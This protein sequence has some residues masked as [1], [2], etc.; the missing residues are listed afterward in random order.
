MQVSLKFLELQG[1]FKLI[2]RYTFKL[3][4]FLL[5]L[6]Y[7]Y[8]SKQT[9]SFSNIS[10]VI[11]TIKQQCF[12]PVKLK[13]ARESLFWQFSLVQVNFHNCVPTFSVFTGEVFFTFFIKVLFHTM[14]KRY[15]VFKVYL[16]WFLQ[17]L[18]LK[19]CFFRNFV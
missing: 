5:F 13:S 6:Q 7:L 3:L 15:Q 10:Q 18:F 12:F 17:E 4:Y 1:S 19:S 11:F 16:L 14:P 9:S 8:G 2:F